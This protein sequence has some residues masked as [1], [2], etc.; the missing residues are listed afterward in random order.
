VFPL[1]PLACV[2]TFFTTTARP[3]K[4]PALPPNEIEPLLSVTGLSVRD[5]CAL[6]R[7]D[8]WHG[9][10]SRN[11]QVMF[12]YGFTRSECSIS[13]PTAIIGQ[14]FKIHEAHVWKTRSKAQKTARPGH[15]P[16][17]LSSEQED[18]IV[19]LI[20]RGYSD[21]NFVTQRDLLNFAE[22]EFGKCLT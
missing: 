15:C 21:G 5:I 17:A 13:L 16:F 20:E 9:L 22:S 7:A 6:L 2:K 4:V 8:E 10:E 14:T 12:L 19:A 18:A 11:Q 1:G 3:L